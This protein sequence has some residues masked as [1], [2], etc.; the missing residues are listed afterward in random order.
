MNCKFHRIKETI[1]IYD[2]ATIE[3]H[4]NFC[5]KSDATENTKEDEACMLYVVSWRE[6]RYSDLIVL[7]A[8]E[9]KT[10]SF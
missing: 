3:I 10:N 5:N 6:R 8:K 9:R 7:V 1:F 4:I 2:R